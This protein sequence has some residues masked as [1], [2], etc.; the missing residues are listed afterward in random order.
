MSVKRAPEDPL[1]LPLTS[2][3]KVLPHVHLV[4][5]SDRVRVSGSVT[6]YDPGSAVVI[7]EGTRSPGWKPTPL[8]Q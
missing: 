2:M 6:Y 7:Q 5:S 4:D 1:S 3:D 8:F